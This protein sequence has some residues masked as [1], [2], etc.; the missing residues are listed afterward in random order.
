MVDHAQGDRLLSAGDGERRLA[1]AQH[2]RQ[3]PRPK[4]FDQHMRGR[5]HVDRVAFEMRRARQVHD[6]RMIERPALDR[7]YAPHRGR[8]AHVGRESVD[9]FGRECDHAAGAE[10]TRGVH[11]YRGVDDGSPRVLPSGSIDAKP[12]NG[13]SAAGT[14]TPPSAR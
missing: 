12:A 2:D 13:R 6:Q 1:L 5:R 14:S 8:V 9:R 3:R 7:I 11:D 4:A 10:Q